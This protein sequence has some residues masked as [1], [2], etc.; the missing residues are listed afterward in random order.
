[1]PTV[2]FP[3]SAGGLKESE[4]TIAIMLKGFGSKTMCV[5]KWHLGRPNRYLPTSHGF[6]S[7]YGIPYSK[8]MEP[9]VLIRDLSVIETPVNLS[10]L[11]RR[12]TQEAVN[13]ITASRATPFFLNMPHTFPHIP[14]AAS[15]DFAGRSAMGPYGDVGHEGGCEG[16]RETHLKAASGSR[17]WRGFPA[18]F[19]LERLSIPSPP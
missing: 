5:G 2:F 19:P 7:Y 3:D 18:A 10:T 17:F 1:M 16:E 11:T 14:L 8:D 12:S 6:D 15:P 13:F 4:I 9:S